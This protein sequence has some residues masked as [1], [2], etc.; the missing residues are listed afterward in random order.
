MGQNQ[1]KNAAQGGEQRQYEYQKETEQ[2]KQT[3]SNKEFVFSFAGKQDVVKQLKTPRSRAY[4]E[5]IA[6]IDMLSASDEE[7][8]ERLK[9]NLDE[10]TAEEFSEMT[11]EELLAEIMQSVREELEQALEEMKECKLL[12]ILSQCFIDGCDVHAIDSQGNI[13]DHFNANKPLPDGLER[14]RKVYHKNPHCRCVE[15]YTNFCMVVNDDSSVT[16]V[17]Q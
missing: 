5:A 6:A 11:A 3:V 4:M 10:E 17:Y 8:I 15:V 16:Q 2:Q 14:G 12:G 9:S 13:L 1:S 7:I